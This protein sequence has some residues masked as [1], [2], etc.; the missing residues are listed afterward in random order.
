MAVVTKSEEVD[1]TPEQIMQIMLDVTDHP[2]WQKEIDKIEILEADDQGRP[3][4]TKVSI[5]AMGQTA[6]SV[7]DYRY[8]SPTSFEYHMPEPGDVMTQNDFTFSVEPADGGKAL[9]HLSQVL[10]V[11]WPLPE[12]IV[13]QLTLK[14]VK[15]M[16]KNLAKKVASD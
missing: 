10:A 2:T 3:L 8:S 5:S 16:F 14:G 1:A 6:T 11:K 7:V 15:D 4:K 12:F 9:V 13:D